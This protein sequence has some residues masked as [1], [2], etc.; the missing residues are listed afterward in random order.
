MEEYSLHF[1]VLLS[2]SVFV[3]IMMKILYKII[4]VIEMVQM[5]L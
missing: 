1:S 2:I 4:S 5:F 3:V